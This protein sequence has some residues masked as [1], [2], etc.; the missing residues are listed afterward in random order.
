MGFAFEARE[1]LL[2]RDLP[3]ER[4]HGADPAN[5]VFVAHSPLL[6]PSLQILF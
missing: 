4:T 6:N 3:L 5:P 1:G 2:L